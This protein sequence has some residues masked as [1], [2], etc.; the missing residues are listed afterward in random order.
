MNEII[1]DR[2][3]FRIIK[4][5]FYAAEKSPSFETASYCVDM[6]KNAFEE[7]FENLEDSEKLEILQ[8]WKNVVI[9]IS[10]L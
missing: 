3:I 6:A 7:F 1:K 5:M 10:R 9:K 8:I 2:D 4:G